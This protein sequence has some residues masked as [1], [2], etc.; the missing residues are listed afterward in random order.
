M[1]GNIAIFAG[2]NDF[3]RGKFCAIVVFNAHSMALRRRRLDR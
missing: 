1:D 3:R 2:I